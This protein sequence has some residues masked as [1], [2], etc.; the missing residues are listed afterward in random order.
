MVPALFL[1]TDFYIISYKYDIIWDKCAFQHCR[2]KANVTGAILGKNFVMVL[3]L[4]V[5]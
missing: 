5:T 4:F 3:V 1:W 2:S